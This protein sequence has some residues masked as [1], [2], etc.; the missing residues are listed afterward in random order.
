MFL[1]SGRK[2]GYLKRTHTER[3][4][5]GIE[6]GTLLL[7]DDGA[8]HHTTVQPHNINIDMNSISNGKHLTKLIKMTLKLSK[9]IYKRN[10][11]LASLRSQSNYTW[12]NSLEHAY[13]LPTVWSAFVCWGKKW[14][15]QVVKQ[16]QYPVSVSN[17]PMVQMENTLLS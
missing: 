17:W 6:P 7:W 8:N 10:L 4:Q 2:P 1:D 15:K 9:T 16:L 3:P 11:M 14:H 13:L 12:R 5:P